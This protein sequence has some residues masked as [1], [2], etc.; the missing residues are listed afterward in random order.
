MRESPC[1]VGA[2][3]LDYVETACL[4]AQWI[5]SFCDAIHRGPMV[6]IVRLSSR[7][8]RKKK[9]VILAIDRWISCSVY[10]Q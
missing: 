2:S 1:M 4:A 8:S 10:I 6:G 9:Y 3:S 7:T 5:D